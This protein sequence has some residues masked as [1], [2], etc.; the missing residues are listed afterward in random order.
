MNK[1]ILTAQILNYIKL[2]TQKQEEIFLILL[3][4]PNNIKNMS[5]IKIFVSLDNYYIHELFKL[6]QINDICS[7]EGTLYTAKNYCNKYKLFMKVDKLFW[8]NK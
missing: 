3:Y 8:C 1:Y 5:F 2:K 4:I 7:I 6:Y